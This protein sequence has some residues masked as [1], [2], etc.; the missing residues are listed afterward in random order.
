MA[1]LVNICKLIDKGEGPVEERRLQKEGVADVA[2]YCYNTVECRRTQVLAYFDE[3]FD[4]ANCHKSCD[5]CCDDSQVYDEN[6]TVYAAKAIELLQSMVRTGANVTQRQVI[7]VFK[8]VNTSDLR[9]RGWDQMKLYGAGKDL[10]RDK[11]DRLFDALM[12]NNAIQTKLVGN[13]AGY[14]TTYVEV[15]LPPIWLSYTD[16]I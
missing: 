14:S 6:M 8:G 4:R 10:T 7:D 15:N 13:A 11:V 2:K 12:L 1:D 16:A 5:N 9:Q 3:A